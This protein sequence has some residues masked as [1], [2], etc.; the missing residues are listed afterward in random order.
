MWYILEIGILYVTLILES[1]TDVLCYR[2][3]QILKSVFGIFD[4]VFFSYY[5][6]WKEYL[7]WNIIEKYDV[8]DIYEITRAE[9]Y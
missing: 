7:K 9:S 1:C 4:L 3:M 2:Y 6:S 8:C 5:F